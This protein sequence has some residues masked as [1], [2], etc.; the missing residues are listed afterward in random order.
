MKKI[1]L[2]T[3]FA[4]SLAIGTQ[5]QVSRSVKSNQKVQSDSSRK[6]HQQQMKDLNLTEEQKVQ[7]KEMRE[8]VKSQRDAI[9]NDA[10]L[11]PDQKKAKMKEMH[12][13]SKNK[14]NSILTPDQQNKMKEMKKDHQK[15]NKMNKNHHRKNHQGQK[16]LKKDSVQ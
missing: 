6:M 15:S 10:S 2:L 7:M 1:L 4:F 8:N 5:A 14:R 9:K 13:N 3:F 16:H 12:E 11:S